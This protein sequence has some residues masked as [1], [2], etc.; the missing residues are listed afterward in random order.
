L[1]AE[2]PSPSPQ[3]WRP[4]LLAGLPTA[5]TDRLEAELAVKRCPRVHAGPQM[6]SR[7]LLQPIVSVRIRT[8]PDAVAAPESELPI[9]RQDQDHCQDGWI[10]LEGVAAEWQYRETAARAPCEVKA[11]G[12]D[13]RHHGQ[14]KVQP[15]DIQRKIQEAFSATP[16]WNANLSPRSY[17]GRGILKGTS[18]MDRSPGTA[19][20]ASRFRRPGITHV[21]V[22]SVVVRPRRA[23]AFSEI[24]FIQD[25]RRIPLKLKI[26]GVLP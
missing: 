18:F 9:R 5:T 13:P 8:L 1:T 6:L 7:C 15:T 23:A 25:K 17:G 24:I 10:T 19:A 3:E 22:G 26:L 21:E 2:R 4:L 12:R 16:R 14:P 11:S 20:S